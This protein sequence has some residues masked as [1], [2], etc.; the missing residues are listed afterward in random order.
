MSELKR[1]KIQS[2]SLK[3]AKNKEKFK[4]PITYELLERIYI[5]LMY[6]RPLDQNIVSLIN[7]LFQKLDP[8]SFSIFEDR[9]IISSMIRIELSMILEKKVSDTKMIFDAIQSEDGEDRKYQ[10]AFENL[11]KESSENPDIMNENISS[12]ISIRISNILQYEI[13]FR[14]KDHINDI[15]QAI[16]IGD[17]S[18]LNNISRQFS[19]I[20]SKIISNNQEVDALSKDQNIFIFGKD[21]YQKSL[22]RTLTELRRPAATL[23]T[24]NRILNKMLGGGFKSSKHYTFLGAPGTGKSVFLNN[25]LLWFVKYNGNITCRNP[26]LKPLVLYCSQENGVEETEERNFSIFLP[27]EKSKSMLGIGKENS[28]KIAFHDLSSQDIRQ[29]YID[30]GVINDNV[31]FAAEFYGNREISTID[32]DARC[33]SYELKGYEVVAIIHDYIKRIKGA[34][35]KGDPRL[36]YAEIVNEERNIAK[37]RKIPFVTVMQINRESAVKIEEARKFGKDVEKITNSGMIGESYG[38]YE[39]TDFCALLYPESDPISSLEY[40]CMVRLKKRYK[41]EYK[42]SFIAMPYEPGTIRLEPDY[43]KTETRTLENWGDKLSDYNPAAS[44]GRKAPSSRRQE[45]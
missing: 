45:I 17:T 8:E 14:E 16:T 6:C 42:N 26:A 12:Y 22:D 37:R 4:V 3:S 28:C 18:S 43:G 31:V 21:S 38:I 35:E 32:L 13:L 27:S 11:E 19:K 44:V 2:S 5:Y 36:D 1:K 33:D 39:N 15:A 25:V 20:A 23:I 41:I 10:K 40:L 24:G 34:D 7:S 9:E 29:A 30:E